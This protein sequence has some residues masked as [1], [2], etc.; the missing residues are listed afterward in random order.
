MGQNGE[1]NA[2]HHH[3]GTEV[4]V[5]QIAQEFPDARSIQASAGVQ[6]DLSTQVVD[7]LSLTPGD[8]QDG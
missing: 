7:A 1:F 2:R 3:Q 6:H 5:A 4:Q 8:D